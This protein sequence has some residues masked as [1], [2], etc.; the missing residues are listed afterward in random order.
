MRPKS[1]VE[2]P[3]GQEHVEPQ[4]EGGEYENTPVTRTDVV[5]ESDV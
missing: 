5:K 4:L 3:N 1:R 2:V